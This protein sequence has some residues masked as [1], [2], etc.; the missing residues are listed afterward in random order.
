ME[1]LKVQNLVLGAGAMGS[2]TAYHL[3]R[4][5]EPVCLVEQFALGHDRGSSHGTARITRH[6]Y[7]DVAYARLMPEAFRMWRVLE[8][9]AG[10]NLYLRTGGISLCPQGVDYVAHVAAS[11]ADVGV[12]HRRM[13]GREVHRALPLFDPPDGADAVFEPDA[14]LLAAAKALRVQVELARQFGG[15]KTRVLE[16]CPVRRVDLDGEKPTLVTDTGRIVADRLILTAGAW[17]KRLVPSWPVPLQ[18]TRQQVLYFRPPDPLDFLPG[19]FPVFIVKGAGTLNDY[20]G[21]PAFEGLGVKVARHGGPDVDPESP[22]RVIGDDYRE[23]VRQFLRD[24]IPSL[25][26]APIDFA[27][28]CLYTVAPDD[29]FHLG[30]LPDRPDVLVASTCSGHGFKFSCLVGRVLADLATHGETDVPIQIW[31]DSLA[32]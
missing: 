7:A 18:P 19:R 14:G 10:Q 26:S 30:P 25:A 24:W 31:Q 16:N 27:E 20:Y 5:G 13:T 29:Q 11:L 15:E 3:A 9:D 8:A 6:S 32:H 1:T 2:A 22:E 12:E 17:T 28:I 23:T 21:M 4:R